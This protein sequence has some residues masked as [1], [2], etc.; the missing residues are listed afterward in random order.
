MEKLWNK[1]F[2]KQK[3]ESDRGG[4][5]GLC[6]NTTMLYAITHSTGNCV[7]NGGLYTKRTMSW[8][9]WHTHKRMRLRHYDQE[10]MLASEE[11]LLL[12]QQGTA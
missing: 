9:K 11:I 12:V 7:G 10:W 8:V 1:C 6:I 5:E 4:Y 3:L 2:S